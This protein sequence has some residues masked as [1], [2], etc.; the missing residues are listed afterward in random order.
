[1][2]TLLLEM[3]AT[4]RAAQVSAPNA[5]AETVNREGKQQEYQPAKHPLSASLSL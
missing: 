1:M 2:N 3:I 5:A 4:E